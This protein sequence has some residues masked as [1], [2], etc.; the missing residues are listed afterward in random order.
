MTACTACL[1]TCDC[2]STA[3]DIARTFVQWLLVNA[4]TVRFTEAHL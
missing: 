3:K 2:T 4:V 1:D